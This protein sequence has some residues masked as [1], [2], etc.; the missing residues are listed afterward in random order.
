MTPNQRDSKSKSKQR[1]GAVSQRGEGATLVAMEE[2]NRLEERRRSS[3]GGGGPS[4]N[5]NGDGGGA[6]AVLEPAAN[7]VLPLLL[8]HPPLT[9]PNSRQGPDASR[10][11]AST[12]IGNS[13]DRQ[14][15]E[16][17]EPSLPGAASLLEVYASPPAASQLRVS[18]IA[19]P[20]GTRLPDSVAMKG[21]SLPRRRRS[22]RALRDATL[23]QSVDLLKY[24]LR[25]HDATP[26]SS[27]SPQRKKGG[28]ASSCTP[29]LTE[30]Q[31]FHFQ[32]LHQRP[33]PKSTDELEEELMNEF[34]AHQ[35]KARPVP[36]FL[37]RSPKD[38]AVSNAELMPNDPS[39]EDGNSTS[40]LAELETPRP[41]KAR[42]VPLTTYVPVDQ[43][44][45]RSVPRTPP[46]DL[47]ST[48]PHLEA[49]HHRSAEISPTKRSSAIAAV[50]NSPNE[51][52]APHESGAS[53]SIATP[54]D[55]QPFHLQSIVRHE[56][57]QKHLQEQIRQEQ[58]NAKRMAEFRAR[59]YDKSKIPSPQQRR[60]IASKPDPRIV[61]RSS[62]KNESG[63]STVPESP[64]SGYEGSVDAEPA[65]TFR[66]RPL[67]RGL[68]KASVTPSK[69]NP[70]S[71]AEELPLDSPSTHSASQCGDSSTVR[72]TNDSVA[73]ASPDGRLRPADLPGETNLAHP[74]KA[75]NTSLA[76]K[77]NG[78]LDS[79]EQQSANAAQSNKLQGHLVTA[80]RVAA[81][82]REVK[83]KTNGRAKEIEAENDS[84]R[85]PL[86][87]SSHSS[88]APTL[89]ATPCGPRERSKDN[90]LPS[91]S[92]GS[93]IR[94]LLLTGALRLLGTLLIQSYFDPD[95]F[96]QTL[97][98]AYCLIFRSNEGMHC[99]GYTWEWKRRALPT[100]SN[101]VDRNLQGPVRSHLSLLPTYFLYWVAQTWGIDS[102]WL[103]ARGP[104]L[105]SAVVVAAPVD[106]A[107]WYAARHLY[108][109]D[110]PV[111]AKNVAGWCLFASLASWFHGYSLSRTYSNS[112]ET[113]LLAI[114]LALVCPALLSPMKSR[115]SIGRAY[116]AFFLGGLSAAIRFTSLAAFVPIGFI[117]ARRSSLTKIGFLGYL[118][119]PCATSGIA[120]LATA[121]TV[122]RLFFGFW[123]LPVLGN[124]SFNVLLNLSTLYGAHPRHWYL[125]AG[126]P[127]ITGLLLPVLLRSMTRLLRRQISYG[128][129]NLLLITVFYLFIM[130]L[131]SHKE[132]RFIQPI[133]PMV[134][135]LSGGHFYYSIGMGPRWRKV[136]FVFVFVVAN[137]V[138]VLYLGLFHRSGPIS[139]SR[140][141][142]EEAKA[143]ATTAREGGGGIASVPTTTFSVFYL[144]ECHSAPLL[145]HLHAAPLQF[146]T[147]ALDCSPDCRSDPH[148]ICE[149]DRFAHDPA[150]FVEAAVCQGTSAD[151]D[152]CAAVAS[153][154]GGAA[155][156]G[157]VPP[158]PLPDFVVTYASHIPALEGW[159]HRA[160]LLEVSRFPHH[161]NGVQWDDSPSRRRLWG[162]DG[163]W[164]GPFRTW[165]L[166]TTGLEL[167]ME[168][169]VLYSRHPS[170]V[171]GDLHPALPRIYRY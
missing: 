109:L 22:P 79:L 164:P 171:A 137:L 15:M 40:D 67:P 101:W 44:I 157:L 5:P 68:Y 73:S 47:R 43:P 124:I 93:I 145:S 98:P 160:G 84:A 156:E 168:D 162:D 56:E 154:E 19:K 83:T 105:L 45:R 13:K 130:S 81:V 72:E 103:V 69:A 111:H 108:S 166:G 152:T 14:T 102:W 10:R 143:V 139:I 59:P 138:P 153:A 50:D 39:S 135:L 12:T 21:G 29:M 131:S 36:E 85:T 150:A 16:P 32:A 25:R 2:A 60:S 46:A 51:A 107:V 24:G 89:T 136:G 159:L 169:M 96:W 104:T 92:V 27:S 125:T 158:R 115:L 61:V 163:P 57:Y 18:K 42:P 49:H 31:E 58:Q 94:M 114:A 116:V 38:G 80:T 91:V 161:V 65:F 148:R 99:P 126:L 151:A 144:T 4:S 129:R 62:T 100:V 30:P 11:P 37:L 1:S 75:V 35:F 170:A 87:R 77:S 134:C 120:G 119:M 74:S 95:E 117:V 141:L 165:R 106:V 23:A 112:Q 7:E 132:L 52:A 55:I 26:E 33:L 53:H 48:A 123:T 76:L 147:W 78:Y 66:A 8:Q 110:G 118:L 41:F 149:S 63:K 34:N 86:Q 64:T 167:R 20:S 88:I 97:E 6:G 128:E 127:A 155:G 142:V 54:R 71:R 70:P 121:A 90:E 3:D 82:P 133:L 122:D 140:A 28:G 113:A 146:D 9:N 17:E